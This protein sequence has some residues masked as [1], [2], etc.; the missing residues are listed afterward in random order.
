[1]VYRQVFWKYGESVK[2]EMMVV[3]GRSTGVAA[4]TPGIVQ[5]APQYASTEI[6][7]VF[8]VHG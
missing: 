6:S 4:N 7:L 8:F 2:F 5:Q 1:M 3:A